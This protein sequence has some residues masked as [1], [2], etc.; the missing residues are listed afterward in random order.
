MFLHQGRTRQLQ[1]CFFLQNLLFNRYGEAVFQRNRAVT[2]TSFFRE[3]GL[4]PS[5]LKQ[6]TASN[7]GAE[8]KVPIQ[9]PRQFEFT[10]QQEMFV[11]SHLLLT[12]ILLSPAEDLLQPVHGQDQERDNVHAKKPHEHPQAY[13]QGFFTFFSCRAVVMIT[14]PCIQ[15]FLHTE[16]NLWGHC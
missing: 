11:K 14:T 16:I 12:K 4:S 15:L 5:S 8:L 9:K 1:E 3:I 6:A 10:V 2:F 7:P 13:G